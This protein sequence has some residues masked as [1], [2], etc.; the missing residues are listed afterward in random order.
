MKKTKTF[1]E[2]QLN[3]ANGLKYFIDD[4]GMFKGGEF[5][6]KSHQSFPN[7]YTI[8][9]LNS[10]GKETGKPITIN[11]VDFENSFAPFEPRK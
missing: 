9:E 10:K 11:Q 7:R 5:K 4:E 2:Y 8:Q 3:E 1:K 6:I